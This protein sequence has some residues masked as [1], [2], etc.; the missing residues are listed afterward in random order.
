MTESDTTAEC[1]PPPLPADSLAAGVAVMLSMTVIQRVVGF[2]RSILFCRVL[3]DEQLGM[4]SLA[5]SFLLMA[6][7]LAVLGLPGSFGRYVE[8]YHQRGQLR[9]FLW[10]TAVVSAVLGMLCAVLAACGGEWMSWLIFK[11]ASQ[12]QLTQL[13]AAALIS[14]IAF[15]FLNELL[16]ALR[17]ARA[18]AV[19]QF[20][21]SL[22]FAL[23]GVGLTAFA[24]WGVSAL[25]IAYLVG[26]V[27]AGA[28]AIFVLARTLKHLPADMTALPHRTLWGKLLPFAGWIWVINLLANLFD[29]A[30]RYMILHFGPFTAT[31]AQGLVGQYHSSR[32]TPLLLSSVAALLASIVV[33]YLS[34][35]WEAGRRLLV[36]RKLR[37]A[38]KLTS[39]S[40]TAGGAVLLLAS[41]LLF[42]W[43]LQ[44]KYSDG[45]AVLPVTMAYCVW[46][47]LATVA[48]TYLWC[49]EKARLGG[50]ALA[51][52]L[53]ANIICN[54]LLLP[55]LG[56]MGAVVAT[57]V[58]N[59]VSLTL[60]LLLNY[61]SGMKLDAGIW[62]AVAIPASLAFGALPGLAFAVATLLFA[63]NH[64][65]LMSRGERREIASVI[66]MTWQKLQTI[67][68]R[69]GMAKENAA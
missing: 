11:D 54:A 2:S 31:Q 39:I 3:S 52:G 1:N 47:G 13:L 5:F 8:Y 16:T 9:S 15:N 10:R 21:H 36:S 28:G 22:L 6:A 20:T 55:W 19:I 45:L 61:R 62:V 29:A 59:L 50:L 68:S 67:T 49:A 37:L 57:A 24:G 48:Q 56:L 12:T 14:V 43:A 66:E 35:D 7:P 32:V 63:L 69:F 41:P 53:V 65:W 58:A 42:D 4:W 25:V 38:V 17:Q 30:D 44:G 23:V 27:V 64:R 18:S 46:L 33:P 34:H 40:F 60:I 51:A 26:C